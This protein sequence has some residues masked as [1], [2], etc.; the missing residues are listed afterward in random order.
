MK[1]IPP[2]RP[3]CDRRSAGCHNESCPYGWAVFERKK[4]AEARKREKA[5]KLCEATRPVTAGRKA[6]AHNAVMR[7]KRRRCRE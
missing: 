5:V 3:D 1:I 7:E 6:C 2:C 4:S